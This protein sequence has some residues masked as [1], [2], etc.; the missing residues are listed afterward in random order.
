MPLTGTVDAPIG[1]ATRDR[2]KMAVVAQD[3]GKE[4]RTHYKVLERFE[5]KALSLIECKLE[6]GR[7]HQIRVH[8]T[9]LGHPIVGDP[10]YGRA[11]KL[12]DKQLQQLVSVYGRQMLH[13]VE[14][15]FKHPKTEEKITLKAAY[16]QEFAELLEKLAPCKL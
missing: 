15:A 7:T 13:A 16:R 11:R 9:H 6:S 4:A 5:E 1:R 8:L 14:I 3:K 12:A 10:A 2:K